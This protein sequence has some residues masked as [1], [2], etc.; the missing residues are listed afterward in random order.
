MIYTIC[1]HVTFSVVIMYK[2]NLLNTNN[3]YY[4]ELNIIQIIYD[5]NLLSF[6]NYQQFIVI[7]ESSQISEK[8]L[9]TQISHFLSQHKLYWQKTTE[10]AENDIGR[11]TASNRQDMHYREGE[12]H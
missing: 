8:F 10:Q 5:I 2:A 1:K 3:V 11:T 9:E 12:T 6:N 4:V 7:S